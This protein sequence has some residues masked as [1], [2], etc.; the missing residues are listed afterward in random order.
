MRQRLLFQYPSVT[1]FIGQLV[2]YVWIGIN[3]GIALSSNPVDTMDINSNGSFS[4]SPEVQSSPWDFP[5]SQHHGRHDFAGRYNIPPNFISPMWADLLLASNDSSSELF[6]NIRYGNGTDSCEF[7]VEWDSLGII[8]PNGNEILHDFAVFRVV[9]NRC[10]QSIEFQ[11]DNIG[12]GGIDTLGL[13]GMQQDSLNPSGTEPGYLFINKNGLPLETKIQNNSCLRFYAGAPLYV[14]PGWQLL[15][16]SFSRPGGINSSDVF[17]GTICPFN[18]T[19][20]SGYNLLCDLILSP[21]SAFWLRFDQYGIASIPGIPINDLTINLNAGWNIVGGIS[22]TISTSTIEKSIGLII[23][24]FFKYEGTYKLSNTIDPG[25]GYWVKT[26][27]AG[28][29][30]MLSF[31]AFEKSPEPDYSRLNKFT[32]RN[33]VGLGQTLYIGSDKTIKDSQLTIDE[34][35]PPAP[36]FNARFKSTGGMIA[37]YPDKAEAGSVNEYPITF[38]SESYPISIEWELKNTDYRVSLNVDGK[39]INL[40]QVGA[41][42]IRNPISKMN[43]RLAASALIKIPMEFSLQQNYPN[44]FNPVTDIRYQISEISHVK[45]VI[46]DVLGREVATL[47]DE[48]QDAGFKSVSWDASKIPSGVYFYKLIAGNYVATK[49]MILIR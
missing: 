27:Q 48:M 32:F 35:P 19:S 43:L 2:R 10:D 17:G 28:T 33:N 3:G 16:T 18:Y 24:P 9:L 45:L 20:G 21:G 40:N 4:G 42:E 22:K 39:T 44:P 46:Y 37:T 47:V 15:S 29:L 7:I 41:T 34:L 30:H 11:Y 12:I 14:Q 49:K 23:S 36:Y 38:Y 1:F 6:G 25:V 5:M 13:I 31:G 8:D 26:N